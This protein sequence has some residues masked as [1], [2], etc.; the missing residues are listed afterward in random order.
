MNA[1]KRPLMIGLV[2]NMGISSMASAKMQFTDLLSATGYAT[3]LV[4]FT[5]RSPD[6]RVQDHF[7]I[8]AIMDYPVDAIIVTGMEVTTSNLQD[9]WLWQSFTR[10]HDWT[11]RTALPAIWSC[12]AAHAAVLHR[13]GITR[14]PLGAKLS[15]VFNCYSSSQAHRLT[16]GL[17]GH[18]PCPHSRYNSLSS[19]ALAACGYTII[20]HG[21]DIGADI[22]MHED[23][24][25][26]FY[27]HG[28]PEYKAETLLQE[29]LR[30]MRRYINGDTP[31]CPAV[32]TS[33]LNATS[34]AGFLTLQA[35]ALK[36]QNVMP[37]LRSLAGEVIFQQSWSSVATKL[38]ANW[39]GIVAEHVSCKPAWVAPL[40]HTAPAGAALS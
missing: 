7:P 22:F 25:T 18:W 13:D 16:N 15:G 28:H 19:G 34:E 23:N 5:M 20:S 29:F 31:T 27:F 39:L 21:N 38:Y 26:T 32:P 17:P 24:P 30:D 40:D 33:Y 2:N 11:E 14:Q 3:E 37:A 10:L 4:C 8:D 35:Q 1:A 9:E 36:G 6:D 12:L